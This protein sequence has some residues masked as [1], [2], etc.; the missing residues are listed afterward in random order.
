MLDMRK[1]LPT[2]ITLDP[3]VLSKLDDWIAA[4]AVTPKR[5]AVIETAIREFL[6]RNQKRGR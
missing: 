4:Q 2:N 6:D 3:E 1:R 5:S